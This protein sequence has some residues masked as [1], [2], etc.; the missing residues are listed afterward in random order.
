[1][2][3]YTHHRFVDLRIALFAA[4]ALLFA[5]CWV[6]YRIWNVHRRMPLLFGL[7]LVALFIWIAEN[8]GTGTHTWSYPHQAQAWTPVK[9]GKL[10]SWFLLLIV[11]YALVAA[12]N[13]P[14]RMTDAARFKPGA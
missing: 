5:R 4:S 10:G 11:S 13:R 9:L 8:I 12:I 7:L 14:R 6:H 1:V 2:N 3:F